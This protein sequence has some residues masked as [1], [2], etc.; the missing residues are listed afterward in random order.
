MSGPRSRGAGSPR[1]PAA[2]SGAP[3]TRRRR[4][5]PLLRGGRRGQTVYAV[6]GSKSG[7]L[8]A[9]REVRRPSRGRRVDRRRHA[10]RL[11][12]GAWRCSPTRSA[13]MGGRGDIAAINETPTRRPRGPGRP[14]ETLGFP[15]PGIARYAQAS[16]RPPGRG[17]RARAAALHDA[18]ELQSLRRADRIT[19]DARRLRG[20]APRVAGRARVL[21]VVVADGGAVPVRSRR[22]R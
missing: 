20:V 6:Y 1:R 4:S 12:P 22:A 5:G 19:A 13:A 17:G 8:A 16:R 9:L 10:D 21:G 2:G 3:A 11:P 14:R 18:P 7:I 15:A